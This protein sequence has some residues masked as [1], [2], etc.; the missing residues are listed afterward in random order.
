MPGSDDENSSPQERGL[1]DNPAP[2]QPPELRVMTI[3]PSRARASWRMTAHEPE[4]NPAPGGLEQL[5]L[6]EPIS[7]VLQ[8]DAA[9]DVPAEHWPADGGEGAGGGQGCCTPVTSPGFVQ[10][11]AG[12]DR[13]YDVEVEPGCSMRFRVA[14]VLDGGRG[15]AWSNEVSFVTQATVPRRPDAPVLV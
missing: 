8:M 3:G 4:N 1:F 5:C 10:I 14:A 2:T 11:Y 13:L 12:E 9:A 7:F 6:S 15:T